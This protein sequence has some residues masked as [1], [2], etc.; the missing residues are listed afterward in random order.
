VDGT[1]FNNRLVRDLKKDLDSK[2]LSWMASLVNKDEKGGKAM[3]EFCRKVKEFFKWLFANK[4]SLIGTIVGAVGAGAGITA[5]WKISSLP[6]IAIKGYNIAPIVYTVICIFAFI[7]NELGICGK[8]FEKV[9]D[10]FA[11][12]DLIKAQKEEKAILKEAKKE[13]LDEEKRASQTKSDQEKEA[14][15]AKADAEAKEKLEKA[16]AERR[17]K[18]D[19]AKAKLLAEKNQSK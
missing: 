4:K 12:T 7:L 15:K 3:N 9:A 19:E 14:E 18:I 16:T 2:I 6:I 17:A 13:L 1:R 11:R 10:Y 8:G 5:S